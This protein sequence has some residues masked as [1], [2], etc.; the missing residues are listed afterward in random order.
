MADSSSA[1]N[2]PV[3]QSQHEQQ[4]IIKPEGRLKNDLDERQTPTDLD[5]QPILPAWKLREQMKTNNVPATKPN[6]APRGSLRAKA[7]GIDPNLPPAF[8]A[9]LMRQRKKEID[10]FMS[11]DSVHSSKTQMSILTENVTDNSDSGDDS[12]SIDGDSFA[13]LGEDSD[14][15]EALRESRNQIARQ[16]VENSPSRPKQ[17]TR[18]YELRMKGT[19][20]DFIAE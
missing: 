5:G 8:R 18:S 9:S 4:P 7:P 19:P 12:S 13:S 16:R 20:L 15:D 3:T 6:I 11:L 14:D 2:G 1:D 17:R 10:D